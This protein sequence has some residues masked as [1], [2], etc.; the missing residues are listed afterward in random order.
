MND[1]KDRPY[2]MSVGLMVNIL[3]SLYPSKLCINICQSN[4][5]LILLPYLGF[6]IFDIYLS[7]AFCTLF[8][9]T[10][11]MKAHL[12][13]FLLSSFAYYALCIFPFPIWC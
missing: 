12:L 9:I 8:R 3:Y 7:L 5:S 1:G 2:F 11:G 6:I 13:A 4:S 10:A